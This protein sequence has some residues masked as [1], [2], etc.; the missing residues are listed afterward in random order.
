MPEPIPSPPY[1][2]A[3]VNSGSPGVSRRSHATP[4][5]DQGKELAELIA[6]NPRIK[7]QVEKALGRAK[8]LLALGKER[9]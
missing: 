1:G 6:A 3:T 8:C 7:D 5:G 4:S 9:S 2:A